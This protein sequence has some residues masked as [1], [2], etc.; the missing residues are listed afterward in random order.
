MLLGEFYDMVKK[1]NGRQKS[2]K[3]SFTL[4]LTTAKTTRLS[5][6][7]LV[8]RIFI[9]RETYQAEKRRSVFEEGCDCANLAVKE[10]I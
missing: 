5:N 7:T 3:Y 10:H 9:R 4:L 8:G 6:Q 2:P 1:K